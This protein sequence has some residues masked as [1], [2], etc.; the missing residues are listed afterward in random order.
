MSD[1]RY[2]EIP[3]GGVSGAGLYAR[4][5]PEDYALVSRYKWHINTNGYAVTKI[6]GK[7]RSM[8]RMVADVHDPQVFVDHVDQNR[9]NNTRNNLRRMTPKENANNMSTN[10]KVDAFGEEKTVSEWADDDRCKVSYSILYARIYKGWEPELALTQVG[11]D[12]EEK[13]YV[14]VH[15]LPNGKW[16][17][18]FTH[19]K[20]AVLLGTYVSEE[21]AACAYN[22]GR[23]LL[24]PDCSDLN[25]VNMSGFRLSERYTRK[26]EGLAAQIR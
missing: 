22:S 19:N 16:R 14:G 24:D 6:N 7:H 17:A 23:L 10:R 13:K 11:D 9:L 20:K 3:L 4:V 2:V 8:H 18:A 12:R 1:E 25:D 26:V 15:Q 21:E 5:A